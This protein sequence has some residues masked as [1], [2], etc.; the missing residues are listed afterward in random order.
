M[1]PDTLAAAALELVGTRFRLH[2]RDPQTGLDCV[3]VL[4]AACSALGRDAPLPARYAL[5]SRAMPDTARIVADLGMTAANGPIRPGD[6][7]MLR[8]SPCQFHMAIAATARSVVHAHA[9]LRKVVLGPLPGEWPVAGHW[10]L[11]PTSDLT[12]T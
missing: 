5:R 10:R 7:L 4:S 6:V 8:P 11:L 3:G 9:G 12:R 1:T 2:G